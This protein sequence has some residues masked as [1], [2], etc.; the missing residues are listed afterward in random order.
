MAVPSISIIV[1]NMQ[2]LIDN[3]T[4]AKAD[5]CQGIPAGTGPC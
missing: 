4:Y 5:L 2:Q 3:G 1:S